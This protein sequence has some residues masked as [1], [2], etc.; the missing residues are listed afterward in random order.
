MTPV[1][2]MR[3]IL[4]LVAFVLGV[5]RSSSLAAVTTQADDKHAVVV[6]DTSI[7][8][9]HPRARR[10]ESADHGRELPEVRR[11]RAFTTI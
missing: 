10:G 4:L 7:G 9:D 11:R 6:L 2:N 1:R 5:S 8:Q 3:N